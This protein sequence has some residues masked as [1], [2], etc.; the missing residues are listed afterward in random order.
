MIEKKYKLRSKEKSRQVNK[1]IKNKPRV[2]IFDSDSLQV[3]LRS[4]NLMKMFIMLAI[5][6]DILV[7][8]DI[9]PELKAQFAKEL[10]KFLKLQKD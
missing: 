3:L 4:D 1:L 8:A 2:L 9:R 7:G 6:C 5:K 10:K